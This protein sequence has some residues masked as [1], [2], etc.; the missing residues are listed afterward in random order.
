MIDAESIWMPLKGPVRDWP[1][2]V[3]DPK[4]V[5]IARDIEPADLVYPRYII[6]TCQLYWSSTHRWLYLSDQQPYE[7]LV[8]VQSESSADSMLGDSTYTLELWKPLAY[9]L[10]AVPHSSF[11]MSQSDTKSEPRESIEVRAILFFV[12]H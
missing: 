5:D 7:A 2:A 3:C 8:F 4:S 10:L 6:E 9:F 1:L 11:P 12:D